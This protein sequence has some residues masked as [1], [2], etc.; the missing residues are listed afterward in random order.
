[1]QGENPIN[2]TL[3]EE[4]YIL[5]KDS[6]KESYKQLLREEDPSMEDLRILFEVIKEFKIDIN[7]DEFKDFIFSKYYNEENLERT[8][9][10]FEILNENNIKILEK[11]FAPIKNRTIDTYK[12]DVKSGTRYLQIASE[13]LTNKQFNKL[14]IKS[15]YSYI[16]KELEAT[17]SVAVYSSI[18]SF[19]NAEFILSE[20][21]SLKEFITMLLED[22]QERSE[23]ELACSILSK[24]QENSIDISE[25]QDMVIKR[26]S[27]LNSDLQMKINEIY[28][29]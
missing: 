9:S 3:I 24:F 22:N 26:V 6:I 23:Y 1:M 18:V 29:N 16:R 20:T 12:E 19:I 10:L 25:F 4:I 7:K 21:N 11:D 14:F 2:S 5:L 15:I 28:K 8:F 27:Y 13:I 17:E